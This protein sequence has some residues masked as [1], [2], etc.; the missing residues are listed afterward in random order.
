MRLGVVVITRR[1]KRYSL[2]GT[3][4][5]VGVALPASKGV[6]LLEDTSGKLLAST[7]KVVRLQLQ[8]GGG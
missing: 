3:T 6:Y 1:V 2:Q 7:N 4:S 8:R 5:R